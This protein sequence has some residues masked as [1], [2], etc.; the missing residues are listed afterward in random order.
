[1]WLCQGLLRLQ[2]S[3]C[4]ELASESYVQSLVLQVGLHPDG[5][6]S[7]LYGSNASQSIVSVHGKSARGKVGLWQSPVQLAAAS[8]GSS[9]TSPSEHASE[10]ES[11]KDERLV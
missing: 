4:A 6:G 7:S 11:I 8:I 3:S 9:I 2:R 1:M 5:R 10:S